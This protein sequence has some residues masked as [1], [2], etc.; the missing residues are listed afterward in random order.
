M[1]KVTKLEQTS[2]LL[3]ERFDAVM[4][5]RKKKPVLDDTYRRLF[6]IAAASS[7]K[8]KEGWPYCF[9]TGEIA[10]LAEYIFEKPDRSK[11]EVDALL[12]P[13]KNFGADELAV[14]LYRAWQDNYDNSNY[15]RVFNFMRQNKELEAHFIHDYTLQPSILME[16]AIEGN[17][18]IYICKT[19][20][21]EGDGSYE[22]FV[23]LLKD[24]GIDPASR[25][26]D[27]CEQRYALVCNGRNYMK[28]GVEVVGGYLDELQG[29]DKRI[30][31]RN[32]LRSMDSFQLKTFVSLVPKFNMYLGNSEGETYRK[33]MGKLSTE[34][35]SKYNLWQNQFFIYDVLGKGDRS[36]F[37]LA[38]ADAGMMTKHEHADI[39]FITFKTFTAIEFANSE[40]AYF[41]ANDY[42]SDVIYPMI[43]T[44][45]TEEEVEKWIYDNAEWGSDNSHKDHWRK[46]HMGN[47][48][49]DMKSYIS[50]IIRK[51]QTKRD[52]D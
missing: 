15:A 35:K 14:V 25:L 27:A 17:V 23:K 43:N 51:A 16:D 7:D 37:W 22:S 9:N 52:E 50:S 18:V 4:A 13:V 12:E 26:Y 20:A 44:L 48:Q 11:E 40:A 5:E 2:K 30:F 1:Y 38:Y 47:W 8:Q 36:D 29:Q 33:V 19:A 45:Q 21:Y 28:M 46:A 32:M 24:F 41:F 6:E 49:L 3:A 39:L 10:L 42:M 31:M 34:V